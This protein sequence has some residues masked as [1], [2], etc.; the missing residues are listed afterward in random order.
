VRVILPLTLR[1]SSDKCSSLAGCDTH[2]L[3]KSE[4]IRNLKNNRGKCKQDGDS[5]S[6]VIY[7]R[8]LADTPDIVLL[9]FNAIREILI[10]QTTTLTLLLLE[11][12][13]QVRCSFFVVIIG[14][15]CQVAYFFV[16]SPLVSIYWRTFFFNGAQTPIAASARMAFDTPRKFSLVVVCLCQEPQ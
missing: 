11:V 1:V 16:P 4:A 10:I 8:Y 12:Q 9:T 2:S 14:G 6:K 15:K 5:S 13:Q 7:P 3:R